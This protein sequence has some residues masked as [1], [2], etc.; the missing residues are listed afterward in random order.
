MGHP[1]PIHRLVKGLDCLGTDPLVR[2][3]PDREHRAGEAGR[4]VRRS[5]HPRAVRSDRRPIEADH[6]RGVDPGRGL[7]VA[8]APAEAEA[9][10]IEALDRSPVGG[11][12]VGCRS[13]DIRVEGLVTRERH[14]A[15]VVEL[16]AP[17]ARPR[18]P[19]EVVD[20]DRVDARL[21]EAQGQLLEEGVEAA[22]SGRMTIPAPR[23]AAARAA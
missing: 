2:A 9:R 13:R 14:V 20:R 12:Q 7:Q 1:R 10:R 15:G 19:A 17:Q 23:G 8:E 16:G 3:A 22:P 6:P 4:L 21:G 5:W 11:A 18:G